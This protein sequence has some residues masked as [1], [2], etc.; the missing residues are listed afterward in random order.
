MQGNRIPDLLV[1][2]GI[3][4]PFCNGFR[5][6]FAEFVIEHGDMSYNTQSVGHDSRLCGIAK[7]S[8]NVLLTNFGIC[9]RL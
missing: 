9:F 2:I 6:L 3:I 8:V 1:G 5:M 4:C 7:M